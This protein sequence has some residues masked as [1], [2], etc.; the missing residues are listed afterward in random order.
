MRWSEEVLLL[1]EEMR[2]VLAFFEWH[3]G[4]WEERKNMHVGL[5][6]DVQEGMIAYACKQAHIR[7]SMKSSFNYMWQSS[8]ELISLGIGADNDILNLGLAVTAD[9]LHVAPETVLA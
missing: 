2:Q 3:A 6:G 1:R 5:S 9:I 8:E 4:W 7:R